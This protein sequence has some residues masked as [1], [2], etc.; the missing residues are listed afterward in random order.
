MGIY[1]PPKGTPANKPANI[2]QYPDFPQTGGMK[3][4]S[5]RRNNLGVSAPGN[6]R[7]VKK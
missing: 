4:S 2:M 6:G 3:S 7:S 1:T 5:V